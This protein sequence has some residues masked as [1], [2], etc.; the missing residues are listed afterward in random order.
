MSLIVFNVGRKIDGEFKNEFQFVRKTCLTFKVLL[1]PQMTPYC[2]AQA[3]KI[4]I[5]F[6]F[7]VLISPLF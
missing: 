2:E 1:E 6:N 7:D 4:F 3:K 5:K